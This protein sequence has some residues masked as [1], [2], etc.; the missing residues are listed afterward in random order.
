LKNPAGNFIEPNFKS[1]QD[2]AASGDFNAKKHFYLW[3]TNAPGNNAWPIAGATFILLAK[4]QKISNINTVKFYDWA[5]K[6]SD[7]TAERLVYVPLPDSLKEK[8]RGYWK[9]NGIYY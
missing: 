5:F 3:L 4:E 1:F 8:I 6:N 9:E 7:K 2:A